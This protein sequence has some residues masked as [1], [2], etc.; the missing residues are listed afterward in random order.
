MLEVSPNELGLTE[1]IL[2]QKAIS[3]DPDQPELAEVLRDVLRGRIKV[4]RHNGFIL[5]LERHERTKTLFVIWFG[6]NG[7]TSETED[8]MSELKK[9]ARLYD[10]TKVGAIATRPG[11]R[12]MLEN[13][14][15]REIARRYEWDSQ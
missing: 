10:C 6:G 4:F 8:I 7:A 9:L 2:L 15:A 11:V 3:N 13:N 12:R 14:G 5:A 1:L